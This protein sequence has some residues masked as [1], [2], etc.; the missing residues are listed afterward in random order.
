[1]TTVKIHERNA[2]ARYDEAKKPL[3]SEYQQ[4]IDEQVRRL[5]EEYAVKRGT[6]AAIAMNLS[7]ISPVGSYTYIVWELSM[8]GA[9]EAS[10]LLQNA[11]QFQTEV[12][13][14][15]YDKILVK[16]YGG[17]SGATAIMINQAPG[18]DPTKMDPP[19][20]N[21]R[22]VSFTD[23]LQTEWVDIFLIERQPH[24]ACNHHQERD[25]REHS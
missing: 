22:T 12:K 6:Q 7:R 20:L 24:D 1:M 14:N 21:Y 25:P 5:D 4:R 19:R 13:E 2:Q 8:T 17:A 15:I 11:R 3:E 16:S 10:N 23:A 9:L 18:F